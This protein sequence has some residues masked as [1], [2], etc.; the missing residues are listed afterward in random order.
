VEDWDLSVVTP[1][2]SELL[3]LAEAKAWLRLDASVSSADDDLIL[4]LVKAARELMQDLTGRTILRTRWLYAGPYFPY[5]TLQLPMP[6]FA[7]LVSVGYDDAD[8]VAGTLD[9]DGYRLTAGTDP[10]ALLPA[11][12]TAWPLTQPGGLSAVRVTYDAG[13]ADAASA[14]AV[15]RQGA[16]LCLSAW[17]EGP[18]AAPV[19]L[20]DAV[21]HLLQSQWNGVYR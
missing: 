19:A 14:P 12:G 9:A 2:A 8:G 6:P 16:R 20:P 13:H 18:R 7:S 10:A 1:P 15:Y 11:Y 4:D 3:T 5:W 21:R 17:Y